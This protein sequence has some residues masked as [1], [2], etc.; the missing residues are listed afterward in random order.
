M[1]FVLTLI[2]A[3]IAIGALGVFCGLL[4]AYLITPED[5]DS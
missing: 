5:S 3:P 1:S 2:F 4:V